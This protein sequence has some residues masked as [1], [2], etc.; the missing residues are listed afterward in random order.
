MAETY[1]G[2]RRGPGRFEQKVCVKRIL[3]AFES[4][5][6]FVTQFLE[7]ARISA[8]LRHANVVQVL[9]FGVVEGSHYLSLELVEGM[10]LSRLLRVL[11]DQ[12][13]TLTTGLVAYVAVELANALEHAHSHPS[14]TILHRDISPSNV[15]VSSAGEVKLTDFGIAKA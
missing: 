13:D 7:E 5:Q 15:L 12:G 3:P 10:D 11:R 2:I 9:D 6:H 1:V 4:D 8:R 14:G